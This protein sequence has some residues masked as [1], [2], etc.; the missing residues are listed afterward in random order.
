[1]SFPTVVCFFTPNTGY[2]KEVEGLIASCKKFDIPYSIDPIP[3]FGTWE[4]NCCFKPKYILKK[5][6]DLNRPILWLDADAIIYQK[7]TLFE[8]LDADIALR[9]VEDLPNDHPSKMISG[10]LFFNPTPAAFQILQDWDQETETLFKQDPHLWDQVSLRNV[11][12]RSPA[13]I[14][15]L[16]KRYYQVY[17]K[18]ADEQTLKEAL[19]IHFQ[20]SRTLK[21][22]LNHEVVPFWDEAAFIAEKKASL[23]QL[24]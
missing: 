18:I 11:L 1:M 7:P 13:A 6:I 2:E 9:I 22:T 15:P 20:A 3:H 8:T 4:K 5:L 24:K 12:L 23:L 10:T 17:N 16:D 14:H 21:K 19:I